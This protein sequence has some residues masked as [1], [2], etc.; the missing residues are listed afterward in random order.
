MRKRDPLDIATAT[1]YETQLRTTFYTI[2]IRFI[3]LSVP[4]LLE[5]SPQP[6]LEFEQIK[7]DG[8]G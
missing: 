8:E 3:T 6:V 4:Y 5:M 1:A 2:N 7:E